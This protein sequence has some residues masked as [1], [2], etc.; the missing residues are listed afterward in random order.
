MEKRKLLRVAVE[1]ALPT[2][3]REDEFS[4]GELDNDVTEEAQERRSDDVSE[5]DDLSD[6]VGRE[7]TS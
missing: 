7:R 5:S 2:Q 6:T 1:T 3:E 4:T